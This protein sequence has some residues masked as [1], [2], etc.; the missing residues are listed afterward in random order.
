MSILSSLQRYVPSNCEVTVKR[1]Q[2]TVGNLKELTVVNN[3]DENPIPMTIQ[4]RGET[5]SLRGGKRVEDQFTWVIALD[6]TAAV[7]PDIEDGDVLYGYRNKQ[8]EVRSSNRYEGPYP[9]LGG[10]AATYAHQ[11]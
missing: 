8:L 1:M 7:E 9:Y 5:W 3:T 2:R 6:P 4:P 10:V 11:G